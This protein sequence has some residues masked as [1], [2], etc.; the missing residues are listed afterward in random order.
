ML[1]IDVT[2]A[3]WRKREKSKSRMQAK[4]ALLPRAEVQMVILSGSGFTVRV[5][6]FI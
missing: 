1:K 3:T 5:K 6:F 2:A 4:D